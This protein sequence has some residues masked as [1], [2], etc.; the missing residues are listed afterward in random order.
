[1]DLRTNVESS[2]GT[3]ESTV[4]YVGIEVDDVIKIAEKNDI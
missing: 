2:G 1:M 4:R 3:I